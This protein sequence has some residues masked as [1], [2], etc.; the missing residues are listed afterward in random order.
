M[1]I[2][3]SLFLLHHC[4]GDE[5]AQEHVEEVVQ[6]VE[7]SDEDESHLISEVISKIITSSGF[8]VDNNN[9]ALIPL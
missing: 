2:S 3:K 5:S 8:D 9:N 7:S 1:Y 4:P 6:V